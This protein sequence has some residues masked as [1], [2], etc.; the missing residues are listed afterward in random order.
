MLLSLPRDQLLCDWIGTEASWQREPW[1]SC[2]KPNYGLPSPVHLGMTSSWEMAS[3]NCPEGIYTFLPLGSFRA[4]ALVLRVM[5]LLTRVQMVFAQIVKNY[6]PSPHPSLW[7]WFKMR[8]MWPS[9]A[10]EIWLGF[11]WSQ[12]HQV[13]LDF[14]SFS[15]KVAFFLFAIQEYHRLCRH[16]CACLRW[17]SPPAPLQW[18]SQPGVAPS[19][20]PQCR[21]ILALF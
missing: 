6:G 5:I 15:G 19:A 18:G 11:W 8:L 17:A 21:D 16:E 10:S 1:V 9:Q 14:Y 7:L 4:S 13:S 12:K 3:W 2:P 20:L